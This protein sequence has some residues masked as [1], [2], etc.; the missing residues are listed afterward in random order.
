MAN[1]TRRVSGYPAQAITAIHDEPGCKKDIMPVRDLARW[2]SVRVAED[3]R[4]RR[5]RDEQTRNDAFF[6]F[7]RPAAKRRGIRVDYL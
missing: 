1:Q 4:H 2:T 7:K 6:E 3:S 5:H